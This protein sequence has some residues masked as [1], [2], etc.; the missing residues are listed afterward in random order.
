V[1]DRCGLCSNE[2]KGPI[3]LK[4]VQEKG[5]FYKLN[6]I[7]VR[8]KS[9]INIVSNMKGIGK[10]TLQVWHERIGHVNLNT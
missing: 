3:V 8:P 5:R 4:G 1:K 7:M 10:E 6:I 2:R 9:H